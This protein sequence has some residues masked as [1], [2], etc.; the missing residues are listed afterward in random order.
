MKYT[1][2]P[3]DSLSSAYDNLTEQHGIDF[4][5][6]LHDNRDRE[7]YEVEVCQTPSTIIV[8]CLKI[9][10]SPLGFFEDDEGAGTLREFR[11]I[12]SRDEFLASL[13]KSSLFYLVDKYEHGSVHYSVSN[14]HNYPD[15]KWD[16]SH[17]CAVYIPSEYIQEEYIKAKKKMSVAQAKEKFIKDANSTLDSY[18]DYCNGEVYGYSVVTYNKEGKVLNEEE[19]WGLIGNK[20]AN[21]EKIN[22]MKSEFD[23]SI[24]N[25]LLKEVEIITFNDNQ[26]PN[27][28]QETLEKIHKNVDFDNVAS[29]KYT[30]VYGEKILTVI[31]KIENKAFVYH[32]NGIDKPFVA[33]FEKW[34]KDQGVSVEQFSESRF[35]SDIRE[36]I[37]K[38]LSH[39]NKKTL[40]LNNN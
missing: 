11:N 16:V 33:H 36:V 38:N 29:G 5:S 20:N 23:N 1:S 13:K 18:S 10:S 31:H 32:D 21:D 25:E 30:E 8:G 7:V 27:V 12:D 2:E 14:T 26:I 22:V 37:R 17:G 3:F 28:T 24:I 19:S 40:N 4:D 15:K 9:D 39:D 34:Q 35:L 6:F